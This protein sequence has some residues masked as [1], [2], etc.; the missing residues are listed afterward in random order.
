MKYAALIA[1][2]LLATA[3]ASNPPAPGGAPVEPPPKQ[4]QKK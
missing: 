3:C 1:L 2:A 4:N